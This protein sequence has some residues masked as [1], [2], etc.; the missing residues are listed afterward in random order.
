MSVR[1]ESLTMIWSM[2]GNRRDK[3]FKKTAFRQ[4]VATVHHPNIKTVQGRTSYCL[5]EEAQIRISLSLPLSLF[6]SLSLYSIFY[7]SLSTTPF[8][9]V[10]IRLFSAPTIWP[11]MT[12]TLKR[13]I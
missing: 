3:V 2:S 9:S 10:Y 5:H 13:N 4:T 1:S 12:Q 11:A 6:L 7:I 8:Y